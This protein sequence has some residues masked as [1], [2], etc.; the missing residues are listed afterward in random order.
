MKLEKFETHKLKSSELNELIGGMH[1]QAEAAGF[2]SSHC[3]ITICIGSDTDD[4]IYDQ[5]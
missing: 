3:Y 5:D 2:T 1:L 4:Q